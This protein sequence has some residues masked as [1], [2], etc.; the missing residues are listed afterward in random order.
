MK[1]ANI[2]AGVLAFFGLESFDKDAS[3]KSVLTEDQKKT[4]TDKW[5]EKFVESFL[6][7]MKADEEKPSEDKDKAL[8]AAT[9]KLGKL[10]AEF[11]QYKK[12][13]SKKEK[14]LK[15]QVEDLSKKP[16]DD[17]TMEGNQGTQGNHGAKKKFEADMKLMHNKML[18][19]D[20]YGTAISADV[21]IDASELRTEFGKYI[22]SEKLEIMRK[23]THV[24][25][26]VQ[27]MKTIMTDKT[28]WRA[29]KAIITSVVQQFVAKW[30]PSGKTKFTPI[31]ITQRKHKVN[32]PITPAEIMDD[33]IGYLYDESLEPKDM[34]I[35][36]YIVEVLVLPQVA[37]D[38]EMFLLATGKY[39][40]L[41]ENISDGDAAQG[42]GKSMDG[43]CTI[44]RKEKALFDAKNAKAKPITWLL[45]GVELTP[46]NIVDKMN[47]AADAVAPLYKRK[48][49]FIH[50]DPDL[51]T[52]YNRAYQKLY[53]HTKNED[54]KKNKLDFTNF[55]FAPL[56]GMT[57]TGIFFIT[58]KEN[59]IHLL[60]KN[61]GASKIFMQG[62]N[63][64]VKVFAEWKEAVGFAIAE[65]LFAYVPPAP[66]QEGA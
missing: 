43:Y 27:Y 56:D 32:V 64:D 6:K 46:E 39:E 7:D 60:S 49:M 36:K 1:F 10:Q 34:P 20:F 58:P 8:Q 25:D 44:L 48:K 35:V 19:S 40:E 28:E 42:T 30:T 38:R 23:L 4:L 3:G 14:D 12:D 54:E 66:T 41:S 51:I 45:N 52:M 17:P 31:A 5:G 24:V 50:A 18:D 26:S 63:Y 65:A 21:S 55:T 53:P 2:K 15:K 57:G 16:E 59:F 13:A 62:Q 11:D 33:V 47:T 22:S 29:G 9:D 37:E 61:R